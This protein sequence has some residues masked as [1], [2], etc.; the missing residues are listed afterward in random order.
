[1]SMYSTQKSTPLAYHN[2]RTRDL[3]SAV[4]SI[5]ADA[6]ALSAGITLLDGNMFYNAL[7]YVHALDA[8]Q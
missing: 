1:V 6:A 3:L 2:S 8:L 4:H 5:T 7:Q